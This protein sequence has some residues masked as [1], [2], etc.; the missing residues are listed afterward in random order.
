MADVITIII[1]IAGAALIG[2]TQ[3]ARADGRELSLTTDQAND[4]LIAG[5]SVQVSIIRYYLTSQSVGVCTKLNLSYRFLHSPCSY[6][7]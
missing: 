6:P 1:Q 2:V 3:S 7:S 4:I 5:L